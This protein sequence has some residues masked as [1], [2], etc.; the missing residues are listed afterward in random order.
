MLLEPTAVESVILATLALRNMLMT[1]SAKNSS[2]AT[3]LCDTGDVNWELTLGL[4]RN[5]NCTDSMFSLEKSTGGHNA[6]IATK[7]IRDTYAKY[8]MNEGAVQWQ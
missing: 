5:D 4:C 7:E 3:R 8:F 2:C 1:S 6:S